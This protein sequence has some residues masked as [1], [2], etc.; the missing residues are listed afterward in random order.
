M[1]AVDFQSPT[2]QA[3]YL[4][5]YIKN[6]STIRAHCIN[7]W[8][9]APSDQEIA[10]LLAKHQKRVRDIG[11]PTESDGL[12][13]RLGTLPPAK[14]QVKPFGPPITKEEIR[15][16]VKT[17]EIERMK[18]VGKVILAAVAESCEISID[19]LT[20][21]GRSRCFV[22]PRFLAARL[23]F[24]V[25]RRDGVRRFSYPQIGAFLG[26]RDHTTVIHAIRQFDV[27]FERN[28]KFADLYRELTD[29]LKAAGYA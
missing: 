13:P 25:K 21:K 5:R 19:E 17:V 27:I 2:H 14:L 23:L 3:D 10:R 24:D 29:K 9:R 4:A 18:P 7:S 26:G 16:E 20:G 1:L 12:M 11:E 15:A 22:V 8:G 6:P 28:E